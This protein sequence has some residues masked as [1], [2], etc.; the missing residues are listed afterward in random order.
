MKNIRK[1]RFISK[2]MT[3]EPGKQRFAIHTLYNISRSKD[4]QTMK[5]GQLLEYSMRKIF[6][7]KSYA[8]C[9]GEGIPKPFPRKSKLNIFPDN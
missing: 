7:E 1:I 9:G 2:L 4:I 6:H 5:L 8:K 3:S